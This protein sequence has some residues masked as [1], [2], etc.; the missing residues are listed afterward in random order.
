MGCWSGRQ[1]GIHCSHTKR[2]EQ[3][4]AMPLVASS[5][6][7]TKSNPIKSTYLV[8]ALAS[9]DVDDL[10]HDAESAVDC[11]DGEGIGRNEL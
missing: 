10:A 9:L 6:N 7:R 1:A 3:I 11:E 2:L 5:Q 8:A 4:V